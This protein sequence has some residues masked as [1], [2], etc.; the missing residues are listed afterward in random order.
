MSTRPK[1][2]KEQH[3]LAEKLISGDVE[4]EGQKFREAIRKI[5]GTQR[6]GV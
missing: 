4:E 3:I 1:Y 6:S 5:Q 2:A